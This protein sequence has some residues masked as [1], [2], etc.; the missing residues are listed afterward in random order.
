MGNGV[1][2]DR[3]QIDADRS[4]FSRSIQYFDSKMGREICFLLK[5]GRQIVQNNHTPFISRAIGAM[6]RGGVVVNIGP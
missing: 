2:S 1:K 5:S 3:S 6:A 4:G